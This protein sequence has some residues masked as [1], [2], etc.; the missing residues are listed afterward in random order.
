MDKISRWMQLMIYA[1]NAK[2][3][4]AKDNVTFWWCRVV[5]QE[6]HIIMSTYLE[7]PCIFLGVFAIHGTFIAMLM[8]NAHGCKVPSICLGPTSST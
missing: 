5:Q 7:N 4:S 6:M 3:F 8:K 2:D 1:L